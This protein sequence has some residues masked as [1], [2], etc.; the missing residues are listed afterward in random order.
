M[1]SPT[2]HAGMKLHTDRRVGER[3]I[4]QREAKARRDLEDRLS[5]ALKDVDDGLVTIAK[6]KDELAARDDQLTELRRRQTTYDRDFRRHVELL[7]Q[8]NVTRA[9]NDQLRRKLD[10]VI[11]L[12][13]DGTLHVPTTVET[14]R[15]PKP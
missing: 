15:R 10:G 4:R 6:L 14:T 9:L 5:T 8:L 3:S 2:V 13:A 11:V 12:S 7:R 1:T